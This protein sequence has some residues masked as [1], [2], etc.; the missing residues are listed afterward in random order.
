MAGLTALAVLL[1]AVALATEFF[2]TTLQTAVYD[3]A[4]DLSPAKVKN[5]EAP[6]EIY[7]VL[8]ARDV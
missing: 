7:K 1:G 8:E 6:V 3:K 4:I 5:R 2:D